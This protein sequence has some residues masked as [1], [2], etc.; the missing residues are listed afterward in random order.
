ETRNSRGIAYVE[1]EPGQGNYILENGQYIPDPDGNFVRVDEILSDKSKVR[2]GQKSFNLSKV[3]PKAQVRFHSN[4][5]EEMLPDGHRAA[6]WVIPFLSDET[7]PYL[8]YRRHYD[9]DIRILPLRSGHAINLSYSEDREIRTIAGDGQRRK[10]Y[11]GALKLRQVVEESSF[12]QA[13]G[14]FKNSR[15]AYYTGGGDVS[16]YDLSGK[17][18]QLVN[19]NELSGTARFR[20]AKSDTDELSR[21]Y[22]LLLESRLQVVSK[23]ELRSSVEIYRQDLETA[24]QYVSY[25]LTDNHPGKN[26]AVWSVALRYGLSGGMRVNFSL[27][28]RHSDNR[29][30]RIVGRGEFVAGF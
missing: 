22:S 3:W 17:Y 16:G 8:Y 20:R 6:W 26:G 27:S 2:Q 28:G 13:I 11:E 21:L 4:I 1:V 18:S 24:N 10:D 9:S 5:D 19:K 15:D 23:G 25:I 29:V 30:A 7:Q 14:L 12:E